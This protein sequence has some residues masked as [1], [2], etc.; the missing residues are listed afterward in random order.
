M[1]RN[2]HSTQTIQHNPHP[3]DWSTTPAG[4]GPRRY[5]EGYEERLQ[6]RQQQ[7]HPNGKWGGKSRNPGPPRGPSKRPAGTS[8]EDWRKYMCGDSDSL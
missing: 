5:R 4:T 2:R 7:A 3:G 6:Q 1:H 8:N